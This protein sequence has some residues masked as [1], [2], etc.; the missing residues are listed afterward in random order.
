MDGTSETMGATE[1]KDVLV[2][3]HSDYA[4]GGRQVS[5]SPTDMQPL[6]AEEFDDIFDN[7]DNNEVFEDDV[8]LARVVMVLTGGWRLIEISSAQEDDGEVFPLEPPILGL[9]NEDSWSGD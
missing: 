1:I 3:H 2:V 6:N 9:V 5:I 7:F 8:L 4:G